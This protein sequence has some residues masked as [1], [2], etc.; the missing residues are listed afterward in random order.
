MRLSTV[1]SSSAIPEQ[2]HIILGE[3]VVVGFDAEV[4]YRRHYLG[5]RVCIVQWGLARGECCWSSE[6]C[7]GGA[8]LGVVLGTESLVREGIGH[9]RSYMSDGIAALVLFG[10]VGERHV[11]FYNLDVSLDD[12]SAQMSWEMEH[13]SSVLPHRQS[14][15]WVI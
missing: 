1:T 11:L 5:V 10:R 13:I 12:V 3:D 9:G 4:G 15:Q 2:N 6:C 8:E 7:V 14:E